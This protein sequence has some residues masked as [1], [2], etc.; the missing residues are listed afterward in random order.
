MWHDNNW[1]VAAMLAKEGD[2]YFSHATLPV[3]VFHFKSKHK[4]ADEFCGWF[5]NPAQWIK[6][7]DETTDKW[8]F[9]SS[10]AE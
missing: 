7:M 8:L 10:A 1:K 6:L 5:C 4:E 3:D 2:T 9:N